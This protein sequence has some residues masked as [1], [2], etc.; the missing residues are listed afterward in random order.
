MVHHGAA[1]I[2]K[3]LSFSRSRDFPEPYAWVRISARPSG[4][5]DTAIGQHERH[6]VYTI[7]GICFESL[8]LSAPSTLSAPSK[9]HDKPVYNFDFQLS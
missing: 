3:S 5:L 2:S 1:S 7:R 9:R 6:F 8:V 4:A